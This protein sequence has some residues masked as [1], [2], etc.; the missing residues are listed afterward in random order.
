MEVCCHTKLDKHGKGKGKS[1]RKREG[2]RTIGNQPD[3]GDV[4]GSEVSEDD[5]FYVFSA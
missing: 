1:G 2:I 4:E 5:G 3:Q